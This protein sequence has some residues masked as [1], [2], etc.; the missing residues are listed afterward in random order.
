MTKFARVL[1]LC[2]GVSGAVWAGT[3]PP[4][5]SFV[6]SGALASTQIADQYYQ[7]T[8]GSCT[9]GVVT[10]GA[11]G[12]VTDATGANYGLGGEGGA[13]NASAFLADGSL[14]VSGG[15]SGSTNVY[16]TAAASIQDTLN[17]QGFG[18]PNVETGTISMSANGAVSGVPYSDVSIG[19]QEEFYFGS[20]EEYFNLTADADTIG[21][22][23]T[24]DGTGFVVTECSS[25]DGTDLSL[26]MTFPLNSTG[27]NFLAGLSG[28]TTDGTVF[29]TDPMSVSLPA[30]VTFTSDSGLFL[31][32]SSAPEPGTLVM[33]SVGLFLLCCRL[34]SHRF[35]SRA[36]RTAGK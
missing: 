32:E 23:C 30:G 21:T 29:G 12:C 4:S 15:V 28:A 35:N 3:I 27:L 13:I 31:T 2:L 5:Y 1:L 25:S 14:Y 36:S 18:N 34:E 19:L 7:V 9:T 6:P 8:F 22:S 17:F 20:T 33:F 11:A 10:S 26:S 16:A 24:G